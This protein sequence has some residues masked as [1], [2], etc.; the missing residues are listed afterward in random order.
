MNLIIRSPGK[1]HIFWKWYRIN[2]FLNYQIDPIPYE[3]VLKSIQLLF[4]IE[5][6]VHKVRWHH[7]LRNPI[8][9]ILIIQVLIIQIIFQNRNS[10][11]V[12]QFLIIS[13]CCS[14][15]ISSPISIQIG[16]LITYA[17]LTKA[18]IFLGKWK[19]DLHQVSRIGILMWI[20][21]I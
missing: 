12:N 16:V 8:H 2:G 11:T 15:H 14:H 18:K 19:K 21:I 7:F 9:T 6:L 1:K 5:L 10:Y 17:L 20:R 3:K 4:K 13:S